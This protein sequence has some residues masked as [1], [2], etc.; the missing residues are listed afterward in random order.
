MPKPKALNLVVRKP[1]VVGMISHDQRLIQRNR[2]ML[3]RSLAKKKQA[4]L[5]LPDEVATLFEEAS[6]RRRTASGR[7]TSNICGTEWDRFIENWAAVSYAF[8]AHALGPYAVEPRPE[9]LPLADGAHC[10]GANASFDGNSGQ[11]RLSPSVVAGKPGITLE[12]LTHELIHASLAAFPEG[13]PFYEEGFVDYSTWLMAHAPA[14]GTFGAAMVQAAD[15]NIK[16]RRERAMKTQTEY[17]AKRWA[18]GLFAASAY[19]PWIVT[20]LRMKK[21]SGDLAW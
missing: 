1:E 18:G 7:F 14:W 8:V 11:I 4:K 6:R 5:D 20:R 17:D 9:I 13:D 16:C 19:G 10:S 15:F 3:E 21:L 12:K 2:S